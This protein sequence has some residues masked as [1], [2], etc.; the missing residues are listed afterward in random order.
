MKLC[1]Y[2]VVNVCTYAEENTSKLNILIL[3][4]FLL[5]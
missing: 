5:A 2:V 4:Q 3:Y 1:M